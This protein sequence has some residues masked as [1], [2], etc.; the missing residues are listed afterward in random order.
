MDESWLIKL[1]LNVNRIDWLWKIQL[2][3]NISPSTLPVFNRSDSSFRFQR[4]ADRTE[5]YSIWRSQAIR[6]IYLDRWIWSKWYYPK[7]I[8]DWTKWYFLRMEGMSSLSKYVERKDRA[9]N[10]H[11]QLV[12]HQRLF[13]SSLKRVIRRIWI[14]QRLSNWL[15]SRFWRLYRLEPRISRFQWWS[16]MVLFLYVPFRQIILLVL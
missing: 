7:I 14:E 12:D 6:N 2:V 11:V 1:E 13:E 10:R 8:S 15:S 3:S 16:L 9:D 4:W 5:I